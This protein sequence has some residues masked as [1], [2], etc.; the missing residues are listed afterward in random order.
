MTAYGIEKS[1]QFPGARL[2]LGARGGSGRRSPATH[3]AAAHA[4][5][6]SHAATSA[7]TTARLGP[8]AAIAARSRGRPIWRR[9][10][11]F[12]HAHVG[13]RS[14]GLSVDGDDQDGVALGERSELGEQFL[15][16]TVLSCLVID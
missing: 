12:F 3:A 2:G 4:T 7:W 1:G 15:G 5:T 9:L 16:N 8:R 11:R 6:P 10:G 13:G 14:R